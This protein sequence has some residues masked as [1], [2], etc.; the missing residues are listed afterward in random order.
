MSDTPEPPSP[1]DVGGQCRGALP[2]SVA[3]LAVWAVCTIGG[4]WLSPPDRVAATLDAMVLAVAYYWL[5][6]SAGSRAKDT[7]L[8]MLRR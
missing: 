6:S 7:V 5:G 1:A 3:I 2:V 4:Q 8:G